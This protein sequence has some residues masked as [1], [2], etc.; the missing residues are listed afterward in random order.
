MNPVWKDL[1][2]RYPQLEV[3]VDSIEQAFDLLVATFERGGKLL[4]CGN[5]GSASDSA[6][7]VGEL[8]KCFLQKRP[9]PS[10]L[11]QSMK[12]RNPGLPEPILNQLQGALPAIDLGES[13]A[14]GSAFG[15]DVNPE[16][17]FA[18]QVLGLGRED[19]ALIG[20]STSGNATNVVAAMQVAKG[21]GMRTVA[22][23]GRDGGQIARIADVA[24]VV[25]SRET[26]QIQ[27]LHLPIYHAL[28]AA[29][30]EA[31]F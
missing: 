23:T 15:N 10:A 28:C 16:Y 19:D 3:C 30:E 31:F 9:L 22:L 21:I 25:P 1:L 20:I 6:H 12:E 5:G 14:L 17:V 26:F 8:M 4:L 7:I 11:R 18:Q 13:L 27:E 2:A 24:I 29:I